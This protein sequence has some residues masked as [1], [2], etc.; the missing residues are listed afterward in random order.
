MRIDDMQKYEMSLEYLV[1][2]KRKAV[3]KKKRLK[4]KE[5]WGISNWHSCQFPNKAGTIWA[6]KEITM[7]WIIT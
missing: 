4:I 1:M 5:G 7:I 2:A 3:L 6:I